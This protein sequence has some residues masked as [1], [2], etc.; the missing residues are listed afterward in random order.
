VHV[1]CIGELRSAY[2]ILFRNPERLG[3]LVVDGKMILE[4]I[5]DK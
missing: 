2:K 4:E 1:L 3:E 5:S